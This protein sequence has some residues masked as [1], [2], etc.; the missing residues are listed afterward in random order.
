[1]L[2]NPSGDGL[3]LYKKRKPLRNLEDEEKASNGIGMAVRC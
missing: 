2:P 1:M 3:Q